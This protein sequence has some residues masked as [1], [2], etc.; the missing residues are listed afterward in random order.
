MGGLV[1]RSVFVQP[2]FQYNSVDLIL[3]LSTPHNTAPLQ[4]DWSI[5]SFYRLS[6]RSYEYLRVLVFFC[7][8]LLR[9]GTANRYRVTVSRDINDTF[10]KIVNTCIF[11]EIV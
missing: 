5:Q 8:I 6:L 9:L 10:P 1:A 4:F 11:S 3:T 2:E 7:I